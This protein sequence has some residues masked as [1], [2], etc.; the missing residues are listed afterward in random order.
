MDHF[1]EWKTIQEFINEH[2]TEKGFEFTH[3]S[4]GSPTCSFYV[5]VDELEVFYQLYENSLNNNED[6]HITEK[7]RHIGPIVIDIDLRFNLSDDNNRKYKIDFIENVVNAYITVIKKYIT[8]SKKDLFYVLEKPN[9]IVYRNSILK[10]GLHIVIPNIVTKASVKYLIRDEVINIL[11]PIMKN[12]EVVNDINDIIDKAVIEKN[13]WFMYGSKKLD[14]DKY[15]LTYVYDFE[16]KQK[17]LPKNKNTLVKLLSIRNKYTESELFSEHIET[18]QNF[19]NKEEEKRRRSNITK[20]TLQTEKNYN[21]KTCDN[22]DLVI[23]LI[24][25]LNIKRADAYDDWIRLGWCLCNIDYRLLSEWEKFSMNSKKYKK[26]DCEKV[27]EKMRDGG[28]GI[29][30]LRLWAKQDN[31]KE[32]EELM[33]SDI[34]TLIYQSMSMTHYDIAIVIHH[35]F[36]HCYVCTSIKNRTWYEFRNHR[37]HISDS[38]CGLRLKISEEVWK[39]YNL[40]AIEYSQKGINSSNKADQDKYIEQAKKLSEIGM[41]LRMS[42]FKE[43]VM[44]ECSELFYVEKFEEQLDS[45]TNL[46]CFDNGVYDIDNDEFRDGRPDDCISFSTK[47]NYIQYNPFNAV[48]SEINTYLEQVLTKS[49][50]REYVLKLFATFITGEVKEQKFYIWTGSGSNSKSKLVELFEK[51]FGEYC[52][53]FPITLLTQKRVASNAANSE[54]ARAK[55]KRF[56]CLQE[57]SED[58]KINI[59]LMK[60]LSGGD[61]IM[62]RALYKEPFEFYPQFK[63]LLLCNHLPLVPSDDGGTWRRIRV[64]EFTSKFVEFPQEPNEFP[65]DYELSDKIDRWK[66]Y[67]PGLLIHYLKKYHD[68]GITEPAEVLACT[69]EYK[70]KNDHMAV[71]VNTRIEKKE[72]SFLTLDEIF[73][74]LKEW[75]KNDCVPIKQ[76]S[77]TDVERYLVKNLSKCILYNGKRGF[78]GYRLVPNGF[79]YENDE[80]D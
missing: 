19:E 15:D 60:E 21:I 54:L 48:I 66:E 16:G 10:D 40:E 11:E 29:G 76:G 77:K 71:Y 75:I 53:K 39:T 24:G 38:G 52:C 12:I 63:M 33:K 22:I 61:K 69:T 17:P 25:L 2:R 13:N 6:L 49:I 80:L 65:I 57:P 4:L 42:S 3:T 44:K 37:W 5:P 36:Q 68:E 56:A 1:S 32:Y 34:K 58:E 73:Q 74:D 67:F 43:N 9:P 7:N 28:L 30:S 35:M 78:K 62:T 51:S 59:G 72:T 64:V 8:V 20:K 70:C 79:V 46:I 55:G 41:K 26:G 31:P 14:S 47:N 23:S 45:N 18:I 27:W 50:I